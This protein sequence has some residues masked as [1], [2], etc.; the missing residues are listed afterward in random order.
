MNSIYIL[1][2]AEENYPKTS[3]ELSSDELLH[4]YEQYDMRPLRQAKREALCKEGWNMLL[5]E[6]HSMLSREPYLIRTWEDNELWHNT[7]LDCDDDFIIACAKRMHEEEETSGFIKAARVVG[8]VYGRME[9]YRGIEWIEYRLR[10]LI[11]QGILI[12]MGT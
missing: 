7:H 4:F 3:I 10:C 12:M 6:G 5:E 11:E 8:E 2:L 9:Q 1:R